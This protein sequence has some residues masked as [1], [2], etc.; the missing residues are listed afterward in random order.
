[1][2][3]GEET[4]ADKNVIESLYDPLLHM[5]RNSLD[6]GIESPED[7]IAAGKP[8]QATLR[9]SAR[10][11]N[12]QVVLA[13]ADDGRGI[14]PAK[15]RR[16]AYERGLLD[17]AALEQMSDRDAVMLIFR[18]GI[19]MADRVSALSGRGVG[20]DVVRTA[21]DR[22]GGRIDVSST[23]G[24]STTIRIRLPL[25]M[26]VSRVMSVHVGQHLFGVPMDL[27]VET[28]KLGRDALSRIGQHEACVLRGK[29]VPLVDWP[30]CCGWASRRACGGGGPRPRDV[31]QRA[32]HR[33]GGQRLRREHW[34]S[35][36]SRSTACST[37]RAAMRAQPCWATAA[38]C[39]CSIQGSWCHDDANRDHTLHLEGSCPVEAADE[40]LLALGD[41]G[42]DAIDLHECTHLHT[43]V[44]QV[45]L[46]AGLPIHRLPAQPSLAWLAVLPTLRSGFERM[47]SILIIE[48]SPTMLMSI[49]RIL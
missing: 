28:V 10:Q 35:S 47:K 23:V 30:I 1:M 39:S 3:E 9:L 42:I 15:V 31:L 20:M 41:G 40:V 17:E 16:T 4:E 48:D 33:P 37:V 2:I 25:S 7:R 45:L 29:V 6:H 12:D 11:D 19:P 24:Q 36:S 27:I 43:A 21:V 5:V 44:L 38:S 8:P 18:P 26:A 13:I 22:A 14:E 49:S 32:D 34:K 46:H